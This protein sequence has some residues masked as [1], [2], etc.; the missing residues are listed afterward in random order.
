MNMQT[1]PSCMFC[2]WEKGHLTIEEYRVVLAFRYGYIS[3]VGF[4]FAGE[5]N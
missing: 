4:K 3:G 5:T 2:N 1:V